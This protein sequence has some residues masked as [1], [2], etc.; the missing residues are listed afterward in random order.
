MN[1]EFLNVIVTD[2]YEGNQIFF[3]NIF[4]NLKIDV[5]VQCFTN[6]NDLMG[7]L[8]SRDALIPEILFLNYEIPG[9]NCTECIKEIKE[10]FR[11]NNMVNAIYSDQVSEEVVEDLFVQGANIF[12][13]K[14]ENYEN[15]KKVLTEVITVNWQYH[16]S[17]LNKDNLIMKL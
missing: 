15:L 13:R 3:K 8:N 7:Y 1:K 14:P 2:H 12:I 9:Q 10:D 5:K 11:F 17:G 4:K 6:G 16:T